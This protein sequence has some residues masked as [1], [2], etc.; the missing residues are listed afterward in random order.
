M[1]RNKAGGPDGH[2][3]WILK[4]FSHILACPLASIENDTIHQDTCSR[5][6]KVSDTVPVLNETCT[7]SS[8]QSDFRP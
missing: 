7:P 3:A 5:A 6:W 2:P 1:T 8:T 4:E